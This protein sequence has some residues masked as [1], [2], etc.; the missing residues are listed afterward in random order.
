MFQVVCRDSYES[1]PVLLNSGKYSVEGDQLCA[2]SVGTDPTDACRGDSG[3]GLV[4]S[5]EGANI[6][7]GVVSFGSGGCNGAPPAVFTNV[8]SHMIWII[9]KVLGKI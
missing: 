4:K 6:L 8:Q 2:V 1:L 9:Q 5:L 7:V 3:G